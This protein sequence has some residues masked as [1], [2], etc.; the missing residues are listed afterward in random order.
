DHRADVLEAVLPPQKR[1]C[2]ALG[3]RFEVGECSFAAAR[4]TRGFR[5]NYGFVGTMDAEIRRDPDKEAR[6]A[7]EAWAQSMDESY[8]ACSEVMTLQTMILALQTENR[9]LRASDH[10]RQIQLLETLT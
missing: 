9:E 1:L 3:P 7:R 8:R 5:A 6:V 2:I 10:K 4:P